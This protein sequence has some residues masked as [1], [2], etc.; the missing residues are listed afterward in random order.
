MHVSTDRSILPRAGR[1]PALLRLILLSFVLGLAAMP[2]VRTLAV[3][4]G[5]ESF[6]RTWQRPDQPVADGFAGRTWL[7]GPQAFTGQLREP[8][9][10]APDGERTVQ[11]FDKSRME[12][13]HPDSDS[14]A[15]W[16]VTNG[17][18]VVEL[19][20]GNMQLGDA[21]FRPTGV[22][23]APRSPAEVNVA[24]DAD[25][26]RGPTYLAFGKVADE[27]AR[28]EGEP[29][30]ERLDRSGQLSEDSGLAERGISAGHIVSET[31]HTV[32]APFWA[33]MNSE[34]LVYRD[35]QYVTDRLF[36]NPFYATGYPITEA[37]WANVKVAGTYKDV[38]MQCFERRCMTYTPD[39][40][41]GWQVEAGNV[42]QHYYQWRYGHDPV[43][44][45]TPTAT[46]T[47][48]ATSTATVT[49]TMTAT[50]TATATMTATPTATP[51]KTPITEYAFET[52]W[53][54]HYESIT[55][56]QGPIGVAVAGN[57]HL[58]VADTFNNRLVEYDEHGIL[59][60]VLGTSGSAPGQFNHPADLAFSE[61]GR[62]FV[63]DQN[64]H[65][66]QVYGAKR[67]YQSQWG[68]LGSGNGQ[69]KYASSVAVSNGTV[70]V[71]DRDNSRIQMFDLNGVYMG[72]FGSKGSGPGQ[73]DKPQQLAFDPQ[74][75][76]YVVDSN[77]HR[78]QEFTSSG[79]FLGQF[80]IQGSGPGQLYNPY[81]IA[82]DGAGYIYIADHYN[83]R[84]QKL[85]PD[86]S[87]LATWG[88]PGAGDDF[89]N[90][91]LPSGMELDSDGNLYV[92]DFSNERVQKFTS[93]GDFLYEI[94]DASRGTFGTL[95]D[96]AID[97]SDNVLTLDVQK[98][99]YDSGSISRYSPAG[100][101]LDVLSQTRPNR[102][103]HDSLAGLAV[104]R[105]NGDIYVT[106]R[107]SNRVQ[108]FSST[109]QLL[110]QWGAPGSGPG[111][112]NGPTAI[113]VDA[114]GYVYVADTMNNRIQKFNTSGGFIVLW[115]GVGDGDGQFRQPAGI[116]VD[117]ERVYVSDSG[118]DRV[119]FFDRQ[120]D[121][122]G[123]WGGSGAGLG[124]LEGPAGIAV[125]PNGLVFVV[126]SGNNRVQIFN[127]PGKA[128]GAFGTAG[129]GLGQFNVPHGIAV[130]ASG[131]VYVT[132]VLNHRV[133][134]FSPAG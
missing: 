32:A 85:N 117:G 92:A 3:S 37:Y 79:T 31:G 96:V 94:R 128:L 38:L 124:E 8:Y 20:T 48:T 114:D 6:L 98:E 107:V 120:G 42:G 35:E 39:N 113:A 55:P 132:D 105:D 7:W 11:Y 116:V 9:A 95:L 111:Q 33:F 115:G 2:V 49:A 118:N 70:Y 27:A 10:E 45:P 112:L 131:N 41:E 63:A 5:N 86:G 24:G 102:G 36:P 104:S 89:G 91:Y 59:V 123:R 4:P 53:F 87:H 93:E 73:F 14:S 127:P 64:N 121:Y 29:I 65:R 119:Q 84:V 44:E 47:S 25:D 77:N 12:I 61:D 57:N 110:S 74:G 122:L 109:W 34:G 100:T 106:D 56:L 54:G 67:V 99:T 13:T 52:Q 78:V 134:K 46:A 40:P 88:P 30:I 17:L 83:N 62:M 23:G 101:P 21:S 129:S 26:P 81:G 108:R 60:F 80:G 69:F 76:V 1:R 68:G 18:L 50:A 126:D 82:I 66:I 16:Y 125:N 130:D 103:Q 97:Q 51:T 72:Q 19:V 43:D 75:N 133:Q 71:T 22:V 15:D 58:W 28:D 90:F